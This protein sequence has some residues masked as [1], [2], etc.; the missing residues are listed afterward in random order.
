MP[1]R[2]RVEAA[3]ERARNASSSKGS[4]DGVGVA[5]AR[6]I[7]ATLGFMHSLP[8]PRDDVRGDVLENLVLTRMVAPLAG[9]VKDELVNSRGVVAA[10]Q[11]VEVAHRLPR[12][13]RREPNQRVPDRA[14]S[15]PNPLQRSSKRTQRSRVTRKNCS[16][17]SMP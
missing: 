13:E 9:P 8:Q 15:R 3:S 2:D 6:A 4:G 17:V 16:S 10:D 5:A 7:V 11:V 1:V 12:G 14:W